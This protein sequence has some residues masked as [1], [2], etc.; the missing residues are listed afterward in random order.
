MDDLHRRIISAI[1]SYAVPPD[2][3]HKRGPSASQL[4]RI[5]GGNLADKSGHLDRHLEDLRSHQRIANRGKGRG[6]SGYFLL[7]AAAQ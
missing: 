7:P 6:A 3:P 4:A 2:K 1:E 5:I